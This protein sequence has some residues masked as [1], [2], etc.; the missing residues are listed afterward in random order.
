MN[1]PPP[2]DL[3]YIYVM[4]ISYAES[5]I[6]PLSGSLPIHNYI[7]HLQCTPCLVSALK[8]P[9]VISLLAV[10]KGVWSPQG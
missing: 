7:T 9:R 4:S 1:S 10:T 2:R 3:T 8:Q 5:T 6:R